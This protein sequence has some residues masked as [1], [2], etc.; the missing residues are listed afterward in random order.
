MD[1]KAIERRLRDERRDL[2]ETLAHLNDQLSRSQSEE[3]GELSVVD[4]HIAD[5]ATDTEFRELDIMQRKMV[6]DRTRLLDEAL[7]RLERGRFGRCVVCDREIPEGRLEALPWTPY[8]LEH[9]SLESTPAS[10]LPQRTR[11]A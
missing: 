10:P 9:A 4:Q 7:E 2:G 8:C 1:L 5:I 11:R 3:S 6:E